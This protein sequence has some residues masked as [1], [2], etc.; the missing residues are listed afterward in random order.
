MKGPNCASAVRAVTAVTEF[1]SHHTE[2]KL[3]SWRMVSDIVTLYRCG[4][5]GC[6]GCIPRPWGDAILHCKPG[7][8]V[9]NAV[10]LVVE[11]LRR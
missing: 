5:K 7:G 4:Q 1:A 6:G 2:T 3:A 11:W 10:S 8:Q 9:V